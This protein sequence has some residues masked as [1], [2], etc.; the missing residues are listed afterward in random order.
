LEA[1]SRITPEVAVDLVRDALW[2]TAMIV[3]VL[4]VPS[5]PGGLDG[6]DVPAAVEQTLSFAQAAGDSDL[7][8]CA[9]PWLVRED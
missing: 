1:L 4:V 5:L 6:G 9:R 7:L 2:L 3:A 8:D